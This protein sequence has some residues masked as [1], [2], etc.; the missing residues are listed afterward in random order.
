[1]TIE[2]LDYC[3]HCGESTLL[4]KINPIDI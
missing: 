4:E 3:S 2:G 1:M